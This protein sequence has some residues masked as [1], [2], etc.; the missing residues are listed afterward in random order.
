MKDKI[1]L[2]AKAYYRID[3]VNQG[4]GGSI[5]VQK[6]KKF[7]KECNIDKVEKNIKNGRSCKTY[8]KEFEGYFSIKIDIYDSEEN[9]HDKDCDCD[10]CL[11]ED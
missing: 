7:I 1:E 4:C 3:F 5:S 2:T 9:K 8:T 10:F 11:F 6:A